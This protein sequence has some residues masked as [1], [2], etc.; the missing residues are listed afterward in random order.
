MALQFQNMTLTMKKK[1]IITH[2]IRAQL[3][4]T[5][6]DLGYITERTLLSD[7]TLSIRSF[8]IRVEESTTQ[9]YLYIA[10]R[11]HGSYSCIDDAIV[12]YGTLNSIIKR[13][14]TRDRNEKIENTNISWETLQHEASDKLVRYR[15]SKDTYTTGAYAYPFNS[16]NFTASDTCIFTFSTGSY[17]QQTYYILEFQVQPMEK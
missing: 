4:Y 12:K 7:K 6:T 5:T 17:K 1:I 8:L 9:K 13:L 2:E 14:I 11:P 15:T 10:I 16:V 3:F